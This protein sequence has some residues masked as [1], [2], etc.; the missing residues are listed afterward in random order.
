[1]ILINFKKKNYK[2]FLI[3][4]FNKMFHLLWIFISLLTNL[5]SLIILFSFF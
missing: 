2:I 3:N 1:M 5:D 4:K